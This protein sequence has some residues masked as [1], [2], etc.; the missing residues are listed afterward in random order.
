MFHLGA[1]RSL[2][3]IVPIEL[4]RNRKTHSPLTN[5]PLVRTEMSRA[6]RNRP[7]RLQS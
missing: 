7:A 2:P 4:P 1:N 5:D 3:A 6:D